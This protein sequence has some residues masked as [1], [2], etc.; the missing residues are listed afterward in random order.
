MDGWSSGPL[1]CNC[2]QIVVEEKLTGACPGLASR[3]ERCQN[4]EK[5]KSEFDDQTATM[6]VRLQLD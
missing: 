4:T 2:Q 5:E 6:P 1:D 3:A